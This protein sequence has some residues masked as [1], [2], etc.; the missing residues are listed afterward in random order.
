LL[1]NLLLQ[2]QQNN[3]QQSRASISSISQKHW[4]ECKDWIN[5]I[6]VIATTKQQ[7]KQ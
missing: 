4:Q 5:S 1:L 7:A 6:K 2:L 3:Y